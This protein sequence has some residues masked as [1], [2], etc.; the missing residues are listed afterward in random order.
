MTAL[1]FYE[2]R[3]RAVSVIYPNR[4]PFC[5]EVVPM[6]AYYC[7]LCYRNLPFA[8]DYIEPPENISRLV[9]CCN[10]ARRARSAVLMLKYGK[11]IYPADVFGLMMSEK[12]QRLGVTADVIVPAPSG[13]KSIRKRGF[14]SAL[15][16]AKRISYRMETPIIE[17]VLAV[18]NKVE[19]KSLSAK[20]RAENA[21]KS[22]YFDKKCSVEGKRVLL[23]DDVTTTGSTLAALAKILLDEGAAEVAACAF[24]KVLVCTGNDDGEIPILKK[25]RGI[26]LR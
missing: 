14:S 15:V 25:P 11:L 8:P 9:V 19:Q 3:R 26:P 22:F 2:L 17:A 1:Q 12:L 24:A 16:I 21:K 6:T 13:R 20:G 4:C 5:G 7:K 23:V 18:K 10:Y